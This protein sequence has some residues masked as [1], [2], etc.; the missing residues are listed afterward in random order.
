M[1]INDHR[2]LKTV[3]SS[4]VRQS[5]DWSAL[6]PITGG[7]RGLLYLLLTSSVVDVLLEGVLY[8]NGVPRPCRKKPNLEISKS[9]RPIRRHNEYR[10]SS[11]TT[12]LTRDLE[13][14]LANQK[15]WL[16]YI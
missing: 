16:S 12:D 2:G 1:S 11:N 8:V 4:T 15:L 10:S 6:C 5:M 3:F 13:L 7:S 14:I 9:R